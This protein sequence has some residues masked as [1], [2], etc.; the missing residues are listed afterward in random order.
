MRFTK[1]QLSDLQN[2][3]RELTGSNDI[4]VIVGETKVL[5]GK[6]DMVESLTLTL[7]LNGKKETKTILPSDKWH[8]DLF[9]GYS[10]AEIGKELRYLFLDCVVYEGDVEFLGYVFNY[11]PFESEPITDSEVEWSDRV[12]PH[13]YCNEHKYLTHFHHIDRL[14]EYD[15]EVMDWGLF[16]A[17]VAFLYDVHKGDI[18][19]KADELG[20]VVGNY[21]LKHWHIGY[22]PKYTYGAHETIYCFKKQDADFTAKES[23]MVEFLKDVARDIYNDAI[24]Y[25][26]GLDGMELDI[27]ISA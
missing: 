22:R 15:C 1:A 11:N 16:W 14:L 25:G 18:V 19:Q 20:L 13:D 12:E 8:K 21:K 2:E 27:D 6:D 9:R 7:K 23:E 24:D 3:I 17:E 4:E 10:D 5:F 26:M